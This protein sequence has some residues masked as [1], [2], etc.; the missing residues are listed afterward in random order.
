MIDKTQNP[1]YR[2]LEARIEDYIRKT[3]RGELQLSSFL[4]PMQIYFAK[5]ILKYRGVYSRAVFCGGYD[6]AERARLLLLPSFTDG[7]DGEAKDKLADFFPDDSKDAVVCIKIQGSGYRELSHRDYLGSILGMGIER[8]AIGD[9]ATVDNFCAFVFSSAAMARFII[10]ELDRVGTDKVK[11]SVCDLPEGFDGGRK[12]QRISDTV[13]SERLDCV[14][15]SLCNLSRDKA[16]SEIRGGFC[17]LNYMPDDECAKDVCEGDIISMR[18]YGK[19][20]VRSI[21]QPTKKGR[22][23]LIADKYV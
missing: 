23:R 17:T 3:E 4:T 13:A 10:A 6:N 9:I 12:Y 8:D 1:E 16:Q 7:L 14:V 19:F 15:A 2:E 21:S 20:I 11:V 5:E 18:G 22:L